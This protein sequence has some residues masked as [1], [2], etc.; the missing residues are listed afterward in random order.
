MNIDIWTRNTIFDNMEDGDI[1]KMED[2]D[3]DKMEKIKNIT[4]PIVRR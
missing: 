3:I 2:G 1:D 4:P